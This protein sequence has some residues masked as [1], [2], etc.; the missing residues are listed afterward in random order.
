MRAG[1]FAPFA[2]R[3]LPSVTSQMCGSAVAPALAIKARVSE[4]QGA[5]FPIH[6]EHLRAFF[7]EAPAIARTVAPA[8]GD[9]PAPHDRHPVWSFFTTLWARP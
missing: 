7:G 8:G 9:P 2:P 3:L 1:N 4:S 5:V 6:R